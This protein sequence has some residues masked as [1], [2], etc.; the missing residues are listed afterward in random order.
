ML[1]SLCLWLAP[2]ARAGADYGVPLEDPLVFAGTLQDQLGAFT[3]NVDAAYRLLRSPDDGE[4]LCSQELSVTVSAGRLEFPLDECAR[5]AIVAQGLEGARIYAEL[6]VDL[7]G[8]DV[9]AF[10][11]RQVRAVP[12]ALSAGYASQARRFTLDADG[13]LALGSWVVVARDGEDLVLNPAG[14]AAGGPDGEAPSRVDVR[15]PVHLDGPVE[16]GAEGVPEA[17]ATF[18]G[19]AEFKGDVRVGGALDLGLVYRECQNVSR[20]EFDRGRTWYCACPEGTAVIGGGARCDLFW[21]LHASRP[22]A[23][24]SEDEGRDFVGWVAGCAF[25]PD[26]FPEG[27]HGDVREPHMMWAICARVVS[28]GVVAQ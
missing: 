14:A 28:P 26:G 16:V 21:W 6:Q 12:Y 19:A 23:V 8:G 7:P 10:P 15:G 13:H 2:L 18:W 4:P 25:S 9:V 1:L 27:R 17:T 5:E 11:A 3:G 20:E 22:H 24:A